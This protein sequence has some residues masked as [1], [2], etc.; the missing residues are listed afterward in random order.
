MARLLDAGV[1]SACALASVTVATAQP[2]PPAPIE[3]H[4]AAGPITL[5]GDLGDE[6]WRGAARVDTFYDSTRGDNV[7]PPVQ[8]VALLA[9]DDRYFY[10]GLR[11]DDPDPAR[12]RA[13]YVSR[14]SIIGTDDNVAV[15]LDTRGDRR[16]AMEFRVNPRGQQTDAVYD[17]GSQNEDMSPDFF[18]DTSARITPHG[19]QAEMRIPFSTLRYDRSKALNWAIMIWRNY[20]RDYRYAIYSVPIPRGSN[21]LICHAV[22][23]A[24]LSELPPGGHA[25]IAPYGTL[26]EEGTPRGEPGTPFLNQPVGGT[27]GLDV[28]WTPSASTALDATVNPDFSQIESDVGQIAINK[29]FAI[30]YPEK[31]PFFLE[32][33]DLFKTPI[34]AVYTRTITSPRWG[35]RVTGKVDATAYTFLV[36]EDRGGGSVVIPGPTASSFAPQASSS[37]VAIGRVRQDFGAS[38]AGFLLTDRENGGTGGHNRVFGPDFLW[39]ASEHDQVSGQVLVSETQTPDRPDLDP[40]WDGRSLSS[41]ALFLQWQHNGYHWLFRATHE[42]YGDGFRTDDGFVPQVGYRH[43]KAIVGYTVYNAGIFS[44]LTAGPFCNYSTR[45]DAALI[46][47]QCGLFVNPNGIL[48]LTGEI[49][50][51]P[52]ERARIADTL[53]DSGLTV[54]Y[55]LS[56]D[57]G[58]VFSRVTLNGFAG[59]YPDVANARPGRGAEIALTATVKPTDHLSLDFNGD[60]QWLDVDSGGRPARLF[61]A[62]IARLKATYNLTSRAFVRLIG[63]YLTTDQNAALYI[64]PVLERDRAFT[65]SALLAYTPDWQTVFYLGY[66]D[67]R[68]LNAANELAPAG[69]QFFL[70]VSYAFQR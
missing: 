69:R 8:T 15:F 54:Y 64:N 48:N 50:V 24:G 57:P 2:P 5:D 61:T 56:V 23:I 25:V 20:P 66:G 18:Y 47:R 21:C 33:V 39:R 31:R 12:I 10:V 14:D 43:E 53:V 52:A 59:D 27:G 30:N 60:R 34:P 13:P 41:G 51:V 11:C 37:I 3:I 58:R 19:W 9:Y 35:G 46:D 49:D 45:S 17:D 6:G 42:A 36:T 16:S 65:S 22:P 40:S 63:Q 28:K 44:Q 38:F 29:Q 62:Q 26:T 70:K 32:G 1:L 7:A 68:A 55:N 4:R 67:S